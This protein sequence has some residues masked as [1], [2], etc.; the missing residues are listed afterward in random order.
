MLSKPMKVMLT[1]IAGCGKTT[2]SDRLKS[3]LEGK[4]YVVTTNKE[5]IR[6]LIKN[7]GF[8]PPSMVA[9]G[10]TYWPKETTSYGKQ[11]FLRELIDW[12]LILSNLHTYNM[13]IRP[14]M[15]EAMIIDRSA[16]DSL[17]YFIYDIIKWSNPWTEVDPGGNE[18][19]M[20]L[21]THRVEEMARHLMATTCMHVMSGAG[22]GSSSFEAV[23]DNVYEILKGSESQKSFQD[24]LSEEKEEYAQWYSEDHFKGD[25]CRRVAYILTQ[26][27][28]LMFETPGIYVILTHNP[29]VEE[30]EEDGV[31]V[32][33]VSVRNTLEIIMRNVLESFQEG[34]STYDQSLLFSSVKSV[35]AQFPTMSFNHFGKEFGVFRPTSTAGHTG[36]ES[37]ILLE[38]RDPQDR[39]PDPHKD[40]SARTQDISNLISHLTGR[41]D[42]DT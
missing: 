28:K 22:K 13:S 9:D 26:Y 32:T 33:D 36:S 3:T 2:F 41:K 7:K 25:A 35:G 21:V 29:H 10:E 14:K 37:M 5:A 31:R 40:I 23:V 17:V 20:D 15:G 12:Q 4:G 6:T 27:V 34:L 18:A 19:L 30:V 1:G 11:A 38:T 8:R 39:H 16:L 24:H 42:E